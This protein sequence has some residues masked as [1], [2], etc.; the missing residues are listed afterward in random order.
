MLKD[1]YPFVFGVLAAV[2][3]AYLLVS[4]WDSDTE[5]RMA[6]A[7]AYPDSGQRPPAGTV[8]EFYW[9]DGEGR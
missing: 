8:C 4:Y 5:A 6:C 3:L 7:K 1:E 9:K 2:L